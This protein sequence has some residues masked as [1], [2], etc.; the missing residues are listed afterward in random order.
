MRNTSGCLLFSVYNTE[1]GFPNKPEKALKKGKLDPI[2]AQ[3]VT[4]FFDNLPPG[5]YAVSVFHDED[6]N[7]EMKTNALGIPLEGTGASNDARGRFGPPRYQ[8]AKFTLEGNK[9][10]TIKMWYF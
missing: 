5:T 10:I 1:D 7:G 8:D 2:K 6:C 4:Y 3:S 9:K